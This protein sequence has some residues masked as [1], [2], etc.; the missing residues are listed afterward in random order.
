MRREIS[1]LLRK[2]AQREK[3]VRDERQRQQAKLKNLFRDPKNSLYSVR[4]W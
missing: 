3:T 1:S 2:I 4:D